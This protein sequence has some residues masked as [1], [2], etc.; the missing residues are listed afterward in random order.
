MRSAI[1]PWAF[2]TV[3]VLTVAGCR[4]ATN[5]PAHTRT[6]EPRLAQIT[7]WSDR[8]EVFAEHHAPVAG[9]ATR[10][11]VHVTDLHTLEPLREGRVKFVFRQGD[12]QADHPPAAPA[13]P[14][15]YLPGLIF[16]APG[17]WQLT[18]LVPTDGTNASVDLG[19]VQVHASDSAAAN[20]ELPAEPEGV[21]FLKE[22]Q[23]LL[24]TRS[25]PVVPRNLTARI[26]L[27]AQVRAR[28]GGSARVLAPAAGQL[29]P[30]T[31][32]AFPQ[33]GQRLEAGQL[34]ALL[35]LQFS[36]AAGRV[37]EAEAEFIA[38]KAALEQ[39]EAA[40]ARTRKLADAEAKSPRE[41][42]EAELAVQSAKARHAA[43]AG[44]RATFRQAESR[45]Q[46]APLF[47]ELR[48]PIA[49]VLSGVAAGPGELVATQQP[50]FTLLDPELVWIEAAIPEA[51]VGRLAGAAGALIE[52]PNQPG[53]F[54]Q[55]TGDGRGRL[56]SLGLE[57]D[58]GTRTV[59][60]VYQVPNADHRLRPGQVVYLHVE[61][62][63]SQ[64]ALAIPDQAV[65]E[66]G[67]RPVAF[68]QL[69]GETFARRDL[70]LGIRDGEW[71]EVLSG[72]AAGERVVTQGAFAIRLA[73]ASSAIPAHGHEH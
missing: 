52:W 11:T 42:Q 2:C 58:A 14:G 3:S 26:R 51:S 24:R 28:P 43:A 55:I 54:Q 63:R 25:E 20:A 5:D 72:V 10:F 68:V 39:A 53:H 19:R 27:P 61:T 6:D 64:A 31:G 7:A 13:R 35:Q 73:S 32:A 15:V 60:L 21:S 16:P 59:P 34:L 4:P 46:D 45:R 8:Y 30:P 48:A 17:E 71:V 66:E 70:A 1:L 69:G 38:S 49:G 65:V 37:A 50:V 56:V 57:V 29:L 40:Y 12:T 9:K 47:I 44:F 22:Q 23:W 33:P 67:G 36:E 41:L 62:R 18:L